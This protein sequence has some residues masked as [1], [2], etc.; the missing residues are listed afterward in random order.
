M[1]D[2]SGGVAGGATVD[3]AATQVVEGA[4]FDV[5]TGFFTSL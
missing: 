1:E 5:V 4:C 2:A 3:P